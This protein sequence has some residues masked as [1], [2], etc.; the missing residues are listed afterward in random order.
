M[1]VFHIAHLYPEELNIGG[2][3]GNIL[4]LEKRLTWRGIDCQISSITPGDGASLSDVDLL[5]I[6]GGEEFDE[7]VLIE[8]MQRGRGKE[9]CAAIEDGLPVLTISGGMQFLGK[10]RIKADGTVTALVEG[11]RDYEVTVD[12]DNAGTKKMFA[13]FAKLR[14][15]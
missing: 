14:K 8:D 2:D 12:F 4:C 11:G 13:A 1:A 9:L 10:E 15:I 6:G 5:Y 7:S 3:R